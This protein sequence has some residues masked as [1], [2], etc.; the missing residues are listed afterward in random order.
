[1]NKTQFDNKIRFAVTIGILCL[2][3]LACTDIDGGAVEFS[4][5]FRE[6]DGD[7]I[8][9]CR[10]VGVDTV[11][12]CWAPAGDNVT[13]HPECVLQNSEAFVCEPHR[14]ITG[15]RV[16]EGDT[17]F[18]IEP[19]CENGQEPGEFSVPVPLRRTVFRGEIVTLNSLLI[20]A[21]DST[22]P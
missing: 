1:M 17:F 21:G 11:R 20:V 15:F 7:N 8:S 9:N 5:A 3:S 12:L 19:E 13:T 16:P 4:W 2:S 14:G 10:Q 22:C 6:F 18:F